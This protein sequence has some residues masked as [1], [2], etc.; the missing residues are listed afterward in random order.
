MIKNLLSLMAIAVVFTGCGA[1]QQPTAAAPA[2]VAQEEVEEAGHES[3]ATTEIF[4]DKLGPYDVR[5]IFTGPLDDGHFNFYVNGAT[6]KAVRSWVGDEAATG[7]MVTKANLEED[8]YCA[9][10]EMPANISS[11]IALWFEI[12]SEDGEPL[13]T[14]V[15]LDTAAK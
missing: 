9:H 12:E 1:P 3:G 15:S 8:H 10:I 4:N 5:A 7:V 13:K 2:P 11:D 6:P 14:R